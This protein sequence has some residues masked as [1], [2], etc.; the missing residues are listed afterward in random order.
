MPKRLTA[1]A[2]AKLRPGPKRRTI[3]DG[4]GLYLIIHPSGAKSWAMFYRG[5]GGKMVKLTLGPHDDGEASAEPVIGAPL[6]LSAA[7]RLAADVQ[8]IRAVGKDPSSLRVKKNGDE[9]TFAA[10]ARDFVAEHARENIRAWREHARLLG[11]QPKDLTLIPKGLA[12]RWRGRAATEISANDV[13]GVVDEARRIGVPGMGRRGDGPSESRAR[14]VRSCLSTMFKWLLDHRRVSAN[15]VA[16]VYRPQ[17]PEAR[18]RVLTD[19][20]ISKFWRATDKVGEPFGA[21]LK[22]LLLTGCR[23]DEVAA[24]RWDELTEDGSAIHLPGARTKN[25]RPHVVPLSPLA[26]EIIAGVRRFAGSRFA[27]TTAGHSPVSGWSK[28]KSRLDK[29][30]GPVPPWR[31]HDLRRT[32]VTGMARCGADLHVIERAVNHVSGSFGG[33]VATYQKHK[34]SEEVRAALEAWSCKVT[35]IVGTEP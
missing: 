30:M 14:K 21:V 15:P 31:I 24:V 6:S 33:I 34:Y 12:D 29:L 16:N 10:S 9:D 26:R 2:V 4:R 27:F 17:V 3:P 5:A 35:E 7:R 25:H 13:Y 22:L 32:A 28:I 11:L 8:R 18:D 1:A 23:R 19:S 20:E